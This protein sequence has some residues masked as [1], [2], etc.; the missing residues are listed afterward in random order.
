MATSAYSLGTEYDLR[1]PI[2]CNHGILFEISNKLE[3][4]KS[5]VSI[6]LNYA[7]NDAERTKGYLEDKK[8]MLV[9]ESDGCLCERMRN[10]LHEMQNMLKELQCL[11]RSNEQRDSG[12]ESSRSSME[13]D[14]G[15]MENVLISD[16][17][18][19]LHEIPK[20][21]VQEK[22][23]LLQTAISH[24]DLNKHG[25]DKVADNEQTTDTTVVEKNG[26]NGERAT[27]G[28]ATQMTSF[29]NAELE[30]HGLPEDYQNNLSNESSDEDNTHH[31][32]GVEKRKQQ[33]WLLNRGCTPGASINILN[34]NNYITE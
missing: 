20:D 10:I 30:P 27:H 9:L 18:C 19:E 15:N 25:T 11:I 7:K 2:S 24:I 23:P 32:S 16:K 29:P 12:I 3:L 17:N 26:N 28:M 6:A 22:E 4:C 31:D 5:Q 13:R 33:L 1:T 34:I 21:N 8:F 14:S